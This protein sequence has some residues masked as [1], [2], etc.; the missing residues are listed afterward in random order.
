VIDEFGHVYRLPGS[1]ET[2]SF[3]C[4]ANYLDRE[5]AHQRARSVRVA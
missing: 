5:I 2:A 1:Q 4:D 3:G